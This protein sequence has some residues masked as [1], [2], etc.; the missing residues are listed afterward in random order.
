MA[1]GLCGAIVVVAATQGAGPQ[2][3]GTAVTPVGYRV[4]PAGSQTTLQDL[5]L[6]L[7][8]SPD[9]SMLLASDDG[10][11]LAAGTPYDQGVQVID[12]ATSK[13]T[14]TIQ[15]TSPQ[16]VFYGLAFSPDGTHAYASGGGSEIV[17]T[18]TVS[19][20]QLTESTPLALPTKN[21]SGQSINSFP[22][23][24]QVTPDGSK[25]VVAD[26]LADA[27][28]VVPVDGSAVST[29]PV[30]HAPL[31][32]ALSPDGKTAFVTNQGGNTVSVVDLGGATP[33]VQQDITVGTHPN[34]ETLDAASGRLYVADGDSDQ[35]SVIDTHTDSLVN[36]V[37]LAPYAHA[38]V[39]TNP[40]GLTLSPDGTTLYVANSGNNDVAVIDVGHG[41]IRGLVPTGWYPTSVVATDSTL[42]VTNGKGLGAGPNDGPGFPDPEASS[43]SPAQYDASMQLGTLSTIGL[44][45]SQTALATD[46]VTVAAN[47]GFNTSHTNAAMTQP[48]QHVIYVV[49]E[50]RTYDQEFGSLGKGNGDPSLNLFG[51]DA[52]P[53]SRNLE[54]NFTTLDNFYADAEVS[55]QGWNWDV[56]A[57]SNPYSESEYPANYSGRNGPYPSESNDPA[58]AP[59]VDP[60]DAYIWDRLHDSNISFRNYGFYVG[61]NSSGQFVAGDPV[62]NSNTDHS[63]IGFD[64]N[65]PDAPG[66]FSSMG[67]ECPAQPRIDVWKN[68]FNQYVTNGNLPSVEFVRLP[69]DHTN[70][71]SPGKPTPKEYVADNDLAL[72]QLVDAVS[73]SKYW[74]STAIFVTEDDAQNGPDHV[75]AH[76]TTSMLI[77]PYTQT[78]RVDSTFYSTVSMLRT[79]EDIVG[80]HPLTQFDT[81]A[82]PMGASFTNK[83][84]FAAYSA[85][86]PADAGSTPN[87]AAAPLSQQSVQSP[88]EADELNS[89][90]LN[91]AI[92]KSVKGAGSTM[93]AAQNGLGAGT[94]NSAAGDTNPGG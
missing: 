65:C 35:V 55:A 78:G 6:A 48:I 70:G 26:H 86:T 17:H 45:L 56:A 14:Q 89:A 15:Y 58:V 53:N 64:L 87:P 32:V 57:N 31:G 77:S 85:T 8:L 7:K 72:G 4:T 91:Q 46:T 66:T 2:G 75:D 43:Q 1:T 30:G 42:Y 3:D 36:T 61:R 16:A 94:S 28:S 5:P 29:V 38:N 25:L 18:Y 23:G 92:W 21:P 44:P 41:K 90:V 84:N 12:P 40:M 76:R 60:A 54:R 59:N 71:T 10:Q 81:F 27:V 80:I 9:G 49:R 62:L 74:A 69:N 22:A 24:L 68:E 47:D 67:P 33:V 51:D 39:G 37:N 79:I 52:A 82:T 50:N 63:Y 11:G 88:T 93:P 83:P 73:H 34:S 13:V 19:S 20:H